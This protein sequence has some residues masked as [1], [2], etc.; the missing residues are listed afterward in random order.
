MPNFVQGMWLVDAI[1]RS[2]EL[3]KDVI[4]AGI[5]KPTDITFDKICDKLQTW[6][7]IQ[8]TSGGKKEEKAAKALAV[9]KKGKSPKF[10][11]QT[12]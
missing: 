1:P 4:L 7:E 9:Q 11:D 5:E 10:S 12:Q 6:A 3:I 8:T 2:L